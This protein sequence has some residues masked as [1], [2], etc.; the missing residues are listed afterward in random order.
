M[1]DTPMI[2]K[3]TA[4]WFE[5]MDP[6][7][8]LGMKFRIEKHL[9]SQKSEFQQVDIYQTVTH[10]KLLAHDGLVMVTEKDEHI[11]HDM[12]SHVPMF[13]HP[14][15]KNVLIIGGGDGGT[16][17]EVLRHK[18]VVHVDLVEIDPVVI[19]A[20]RQWLPQTSSEFNNPKLQI[21]TLDGVEFV[22]K[23]D[24]K[25]DVVIVDSSDPIGPAAPLF[26]VEFYKDID[27]CL[28]DEGIIVSQCESPHYHQA[29]QKTL[30]KILKQLF[31]MVHLYTYTNLSYPGGFW[32]F[33]Y[34]SKKLCPY[35][36][37]APQKVAASGLDFQYYNAGL[38]LASFQ[39]PSFLAKEYKDI[40]TPLPELIVANRQ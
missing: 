14:N 40:L 6:S 34:A 17:R 8:N 13:V 28:T 20:C 16:A 39:L 36:D 30:L 9:F 31:P 24:K 3:E 19:E 11:Y 35:K 5:E 37:F 23:S 12:I 18:S 21:H 38:H 22:K 2:S 25:Y 29:M 10:G 26:N 7:D 1:K 15:P 33:S 27:A 4:R 32:A